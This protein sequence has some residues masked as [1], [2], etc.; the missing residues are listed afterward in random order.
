MPDPS[1]QAGWG[2]SQ[3]IS[4]GH[5]AFDVGSGSSMSSASSSSSVEY[6]PNFHRFQSRNTELDLERRRSGL[7]QALSRIVTQRLQH[8]ITVGESVK[9]RP[10]K[11]PFLAF[12]AGKPY[13]PQLP[14]RE[15]YVVEFDSPDDPLYPLNWSL[16]TKQVFCPLIPINSSAK[17]KC[18]L[19]CGLARC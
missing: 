14:N 16:K 17:N 15:D 12:G 8:S 3:T 13:P 7:S 1:P 19:E 9:S 4:R 2:R 11:L 18:V 5:Q 10:S 6:N